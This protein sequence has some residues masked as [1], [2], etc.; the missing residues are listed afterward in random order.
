MAGLR[1]T[2]DY[3]AAEDEDQETKLEQSTLALEI[4]GIRVRF[5]L[6][7]WRFSKYVRSFRFLCQHYL[8]VKVA[9][10]GERVSLVREP[11][12]PHDRNAIRV[13]NCIGQQIGHI[14]RKQAATLA[15]LIDKG[16]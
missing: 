11:K 15:P 5:I 1:V 14:K 6:Q 12:N 9:S 16:E 10:K 8:G 4:V 13:N 3:L 2:E 7:I